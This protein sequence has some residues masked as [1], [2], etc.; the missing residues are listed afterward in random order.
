[1]SA[2][3]VTKN[4]R[5]KH[6]DKLFIG[7]EW[8]APSTGAKIAVVSPITEEMIFSFA[9]ARE[10]DVDRAVAAARKAFDE[11]PWPRLS[12]AERA[13]YIR[14]FSEAIAA[15]NDE[16]GHAWTNQTGMVH[17]LAGATKDFVCPIWDQHVGLADTFEFEKEYA[18]LAGGGRGYILREPIGVAAGIV[19]WNAPL[20]ISSLKLAPALLA[21]CTF[22]LKASPE[23]PIEAYILAEIAEEIGLPKGVFNVIAADR[24]ASEHL[25]RHRGVDKVSFTGSTAVGKRVASI[26]S[27]RMG[28]YTMELGGKSAAIILDDMSVE[29][30]VAGLTADICIMSGQYC[31]A[32]SR[33]IVPR[34]R[35]DDF[36]SEFKRVFSAARVGDPYDPE[37]DLGPLAMSRQLD[38]VLGY[39]GKGKEEGATLVAGGGRPAGLDRGFFVEPTIFA[40]VDNGMTIAREE[41]F[42]PVISLIAA[43]D[44]GDAIRIANDSPFG[45]NGAVLTHDDDRAYQVMRQIRAGNVS[46]NRFRQDLTLGFGGYKESGVGREGGADGL[47]AYLESKTVLLNNAR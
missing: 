13:G 46:Q 15:R 10:A 28:R 44:E 7:G 19:P 12:P 39:I 9:E 2:A 27:E 16:L 31:M 6:A 30:A 42:G 36:A 25:V 33:V 29:E 21:G 35:H 1:M 43:E 22:I 24:T 3:E 26:V 32:L 34:R 23:T 20:L 38:R 5:I 11:G 40:N 14:K 17:A 18:S 47:A 37:S 45:L 41:I 8:V 4:I